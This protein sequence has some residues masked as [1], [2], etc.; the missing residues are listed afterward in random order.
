LVGDGGSAVGGPYVKGVHA[1]SAR[2]NVVVDAVAC[3]PDHTTD[4]ADAIVSQIAQKIPQ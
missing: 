1:L 2:N 4:Q 3:S